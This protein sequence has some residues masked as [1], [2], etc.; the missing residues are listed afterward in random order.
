M[1][2]MDQKTRGKLRSS[3]RLVEASDIVDAKN[4]ISEKVLFDE[5]HRI[6]RKFLRPIKG[7]GTLILRTNEEAFE[8]DVEALRSMVASF[9]AALRQ[10]L[11]GIYDENAKRL[12]KA[13]LP[14]VAKHPPEEWIGALGLR[15]ERKDIEQ[16]LYKTLLNAFGDPETLLRDMRV[17]RNF[18]GV[19]YTTLIDPNFIA[20]AQKVFPNLKLHEEYDAARGDA[21]QPPAQPPGPSPDQPTLFPS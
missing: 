7:Y 6:G 18:K 4:K 17:N 8:R 5:R 12:T 1:A 13:L 21:T 16:M 11:T 15:P 20:E 2:K 19:I 9:Q 3:F 10:R 14:A